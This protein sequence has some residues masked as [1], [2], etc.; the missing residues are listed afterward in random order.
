MPPEA[1][2]LNLYHDYSEAECQEL[3][4]EVTYCDTNRSSVVI[5]LWGML[6]LVV[7]KFVSWCICTGCVKLCSLLMKKELMN[8]LYNFVMVNSHL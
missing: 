5:L 7:W 8:F 6:G 2:P 1:S 3:Q 4:E